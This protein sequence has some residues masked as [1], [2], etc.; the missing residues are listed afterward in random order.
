MPFKD[1]EAKKACHTKYMR[2]VWYPANRD[3]HIGMVNASRGKRRLLY[4]QLIHQIKVQSGCADCGIRDPRVLDF[5]HV[6]GAKHYEV[7]FL[8]SGAYSLESILREINKCV[9]RCANCHR[10]VT[11]ERRQKRKSSVQSPTAS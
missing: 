5:D 10:I 2:E 3:K 4:R 9:V 1:P 6:E 8:T 7:S 11:W